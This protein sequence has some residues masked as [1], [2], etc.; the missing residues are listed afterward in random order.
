M[1]AAGTLIS[2]PRGAGVNFSPGRL[3]GTEMLGCLGRWV[4]SPLLLEEIVGRRTLGSFT[5]PLASLGHTTFTFGDTMIHPYAFILT[6]S[7]QE[8]PT[9]N[10]QHF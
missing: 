10:P 5:Y 7:V 4:M 3:S 8:N 6:E 9:S 2:V 1:E